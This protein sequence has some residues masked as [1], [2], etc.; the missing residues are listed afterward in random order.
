[1]KREDSGSKVALHGELM[2]DEQDTFA[3][4]HVNE[5][6]KSK[7]LVH[8]GVTLLGGHSFLFLITSKV[9]QVNLR[10]GIQFSPLV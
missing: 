6:S 3:F 9:N 5:I 7:V 2:A 4:T 8:K 1:M 10:Q